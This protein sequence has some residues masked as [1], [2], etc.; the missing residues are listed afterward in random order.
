M[1]ARI[2]NRKLL[3]LVKRLYNNPAVLDTPVK[4]KPRVLSGIQPTGI[5]HIGNYLGAIKNWVQ[6]QDQFDDV[7]YTIVDLHALTVPNDPKTLRENIYKMAA[8]LLACGIDTNKSI[9]FQQSQVPHHTDLAWL[10]GCLCTL[11]RLQHLP[12]WKEKSKISENPGIGL[13]TYPILQA[14]DILIYRATHVP[15]GED[16]IHH[17]ELTRDLAKIFNNKF[18]FNFPRPKDIMGEGPRIKSLR[19]PS[20]KMSKSDVNSKS[21]IE[22][23]DTPDQIVDKIGKSHS[24]S[25]PG[26]SYDPESR[27]GISNLL[28]IHAA[29]TNETVENVCE[30][31]ISL[32]KVQYKTK[33]SDIIVECLGPIRQETE[34]ILSDRHYLDTV[35]GKGK[36]KAAVITENTWKEVQ[37]SVG[38]L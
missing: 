35:L 37:N 33:L 17:L 28:Q 36:E 4:L 20:A 13:F 15:V 23:T 38:L 5:P 18:N 3:Y 31:C 10:L 34:R 22:I 26:I 32:N 24:D 16:Q 29:F 19:N 7:L 27:P 30:Q 6:L 25:I 1:S 21:R 12:Q 14:A 8:S 9:L 2:K 11:P